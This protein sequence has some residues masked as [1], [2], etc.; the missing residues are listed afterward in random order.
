MH[1]FVLPDCMEWKF[2]LSPNI[3]WMPRCGQAEC[4]PCCNTAQTFSEQCLL[5]TG[6]GQSQATSL[7]Q[8]GRE[9]SERVQQTFSVGVPIPP[10][11]RARP[12]LPS[13]GD[14]HSLMCPG[15]EVLLTQLR[16]T[17]REIQKVRLSAT[18][19]QR[20]MVPSNEY[21]VPDCKCGQK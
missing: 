19:Q 15:E 17:Q 5:L 9:V 16:N 6:F 12:Q 11:M 13:I 1:P 14:I 3:S 10:D 21:G 8:L 20:F 2:A 4:D 18:Q 7:D